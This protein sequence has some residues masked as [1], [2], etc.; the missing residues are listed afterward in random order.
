M[1]NSSQ[2]HAAPASAPVP[3]SLFYV[4]GI[5]APGVKWMRGLN[6]AA[7]AAIISLIFL[8]P[9][10]LLGY[11]FLASQFDQ[12]NFSAK[13]RTGV[14]AFRQFLPV[15]TGVL[16][17]RNAT[18]ATLGGFD[19]RSPYQA[20]RA[21]TD[22]ALNAFD[23][24]LSESGDA[25]LL[26]PEFDKLKLAW[27]DTAKSSNGADSQGRTVFGPVTASII[28]LLNTIGDN[29]NLVLDPDL[30]S[31]YLMDA[32][33][34][35]MP[36]L[37]E[38]VG[39]LW[40]WGTY[41]L[42]HPGLSVA[43]ERRYLVW[44]VGVEA[45][46]KQSRSFLQR[47]LV[48]TP[49]LSAQLD[50][51]ILDDLAAFH[52]L[53][54]DHELLIRQPNLTPGQFYAKGEAA[55]MQLLSFYDKG[56][57]ALDALLLAR[58]DAI[59][60]R[61]VWIGVVV[62]VAFLLA[63]YLFYSFFMV[64]RGGLRLISQHLQEMALGDLRRP[65]GQP[66]GSD[67]P[68]KVILDLRQAYDA[69]H[70]LILKVRHSAG[71]LHE[72]SDE[73]SCASLDLQGRTESAASTL[74]EQSATMEQISKGVGATAERAVMA[75]TFAAENANVAEKGGKMFSE[76]I[77]TM[78]EIQT[79][80]TKINDIIGV[81]DGIAFQTNILA[82]NAAV[83]SARA[84]EA[85][86]GFA[87]VASEVRLLAKRSASAAHEIKAL[88]STSVDKITSG[89]LAVEEAG[90]TMGEVVANARQI[91]VFVSDI[92]VSARE[93]AV[94]LEQAGQAIH[95]LDRNTQQ[96]AALVEQ[97]TAAAGTLRQQADALQAELANFQVE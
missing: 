48:A 88:I 16:K 78:R 33:V 66:W 11:F 75:A 22:Q 41:A 50:V 96:N 57:P 36:Q 14:V 61:L 29:S 18:R 87:V 68:A 69:L 71:E 70:L 82:L 97:T 56:L 2:F 81:I 89:T 51:K 3:A 79:S 44:A 35:S 21:Q 25:L 23:K 5:W 54:Q 47:A 8:V 90:Q 65:P 58:I 40:G 52:K 20:G 13:E 73:I 46:L 94:G 39:Q 95:E 19:G 84:G 60:H 55:V 80:S 92:S 27:A 30:D 7:K 76:V 53:A 42:A 38:D 17:T 28:T 4:H 10:V 85:G 93:Q 1:K 34:L 43:D 63:F 15:Y 59:K 24:Y 12:I 9:A 72:A 26:K 37:L 64:T 86:R 62:F 32:M 74:E 83:E 77:S 49:A 6:F 67:E 31:F 91:N 45:G